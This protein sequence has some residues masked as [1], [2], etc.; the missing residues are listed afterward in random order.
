MFG[1]YYE[2][3][4]QHMNYNVSHWL[5]VFGEHHVLLCCC[6]DQVFRLNAR[7]EV[8]LILLATFNDRI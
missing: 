2:V 1:P 6:V 5:P 4:K 3:I 8:L 7:S